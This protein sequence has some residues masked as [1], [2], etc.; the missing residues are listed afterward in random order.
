M[1]EIGIERFT[2]GHGEKNQAQRD[3]P[4]VAVIGQEAHAIVRIDRQQDMRIV[5]DVHQTDNRD[6]NEPNQHDWPEEGGDLRRAAA[7][8]GKQHDKNSDGEADDIMLERRRRE[9]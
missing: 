3:Q 2:A 4:D 1:T 6:R 9:L 8:H 7:L 5:A